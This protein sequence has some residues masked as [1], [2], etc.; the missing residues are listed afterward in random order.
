MEIGDL[1]RFGSTTPVN[2][3]AIQ[4]IVGTVVST[5]GIMICTI[6]LDEPYKMGSVDVLWPDARMIKDEVFASLEVI[7]E[8][9]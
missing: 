3:T 1:V 5:D 6:G 8:N 7:N 4:K 2:R 9:R